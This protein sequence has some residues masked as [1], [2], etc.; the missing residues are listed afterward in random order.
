M[1]YTKETKSFQMSFT[2]IKSL[3]NEQNFFQKS[4]RRQII[5]TRGSI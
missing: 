5:D 1:G 2:R 3:S 4:Q